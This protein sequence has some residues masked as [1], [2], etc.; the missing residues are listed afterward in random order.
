[1][2]NSAIL[3]ITASVF[4]NQLSAEINKLV[5]RSEY[6]KVGDVICDIGDPIEGI[7][8]YRILSGNKNGYYKLDPESGIIKIAKEIKDRFGAVHT[9]ILKIDGGGTVYNVKIVDGFDYFVNNLPES[10]N[11]LSD[12]GENFVDLNS[13]WSVCNNLWGKGEAVPN[14]DFRIATI[15][16]N[17]MPD[18][19]ILIWDVPSLAKDYGGAAVWCYNNVMWGNK[20]GLREDLP[21][22]PF[23]VKN[24]KNL[25]LDF[26][27]EQIFGNDQFKIAMNLYTFDESNLA[28]YCKSDG[29]FFLVF[30]QVN[31]WIPEYPY[32][33]PDIEIMGKTFALLYDD[34][35]N[36]R[37]RERRRVIIKESERLMN[38]KL[39]IKNLFDIFINQNYINPSQYIQNIHLG[40]EVTSGFGAVRFN[41]FNIEM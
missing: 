39:D 11:V 33:L 40:I 35:K 17:R 22:F 23:Q 27:F 38:G 16:K 8:N 21:S 1:M 7:F 9:D 13:E 36:G 14:V 25:T 26:S 32:S 30:D 41:K 28:S 5:H 15:H 34:Y 6:E 19:C 12:H 37:A 10:Y 24:I 31:Q 4:I 18:T 29:D 2:I 3:T 20:G